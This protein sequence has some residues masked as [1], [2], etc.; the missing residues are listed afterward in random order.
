MTTFQDDK[1]NRIADTGW[2]PVPK[3]MRLVILAMA[4]LVV[5]LFSAVLIQPVDSDPLTETSILDKNGRVDHAFVDNNNLPNGVE[6][7]IY[8]AIYDDTLYVDGRE[9]YEFAEMDNFYGDMAE[10]HDRPNWEYVD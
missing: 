5:L 2:M 1:M 10:L 7:Q 8:W 4:A 3:D 6:G 9:G